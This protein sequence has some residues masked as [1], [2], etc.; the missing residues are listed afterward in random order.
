MR[1]TVGMENSSPNWSKITPVPVSVLLFSSERGKIIVSDFIAERDASQ[2]P[3]HVIYKLSVT[4]Y[5]LVDRA[6]LESDSDI[7][8]R[9]FFDSK[10]K[11]KPSFNSFV[12]Y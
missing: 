7:S 4:L 12:K 6:R 11:H 10:F 8:L 2:L 5:A 3:L 1:A 9:V